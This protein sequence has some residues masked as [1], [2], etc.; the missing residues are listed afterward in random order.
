M[1]SERFDTILN[2]MTLRVFI[3]AGPLVADVMRD[4]YFE[5][6]ERPCCYLTRHGQT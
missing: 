2:C 4:G 1:L 5:G 3:S 6:P